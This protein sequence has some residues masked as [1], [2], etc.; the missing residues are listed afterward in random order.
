MID[1]TESLSFSIQANPGVYAILLGSG[2]SRAAEIPTG[3]EITLDL[4]RKLAGVC[5]EECEPD[6]ERWFQAKF[7]HA[8]DY[9]QL[10][11]ELAKTPAERQQLLRPYFERSEQE[12]EEGLKQ[13]TAA[14]HAISQLSA[15]GFIRVIVTTNFDRL[16]ETAMAE[17]GVVPTVLS[18]PDQVEGAL[19][20]IHTRCCVFK[21]HGD[22]LD[23]RIRNTSRELENYP[24]VF[25]QLLNRI[26]DEFGLVV[27]GWSATWDVALRD[28]MYR[29]PSRRFT[30]YWA[31]LGKPSDE[32]QRL[33]E[34]RRAEVVPI[35]DADSFFQ[36]VQHNVEAIEEFRKPHPLSTEAA[37]ASLK[38]YL[39]EH[40]YRLQLEGLIED[41]VRS[42]LTDTSGPDFDVN[43]PQPTTET[44]TGRVRKFESVC[45]TLVAMATVGG[46]WG[47]AEHCETWQRALQRLSMVPRPGGKVEWSDLR[48]YPGMLLLYT[49]G[50][51]AVEADRL[52]FLGRVFSTP[53]HQESNKRMTVVQAFAP[54]QRFE[55]RGPM[56]ML[57]GMENYQLPLNEWMFK[58]LRQF[59]N[60][61]IPD[62]DRYRF[63]FVKLEILMSLNSVYRPSPAWPG[64]TRGIFLYYFET[65]RAV[66]QEITDSI[67][68]HRDESP[69][70]RADIFG[71]TSEDCMQRID[72]L[73]QW[74]SDEVIRQFS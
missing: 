38:R 68:D 32:A 51:G 61:L 19:P 26:F 7:N 22:Y 4:V 72:D 31:A 34:N 47:E 30:T 48:L 13:P 59:T 52:A 50:L 15:R 35:E 41:A 44:V 55:P 6:P 42:I 69:F 36:E 46:R 5:G 64:T 66:L 54:Y 2:V 53:V 57:E 27:C 16:L 62:E 56:T 49:L 18:S 20:L 9:S 28:A 11:D 29:A 43:E 17:A 63:N 24:E 1:P 73:Q 21:V 37:V 10:L 14:H 71:Q 40:K 74:I 65:S 33:I 67:A 70:V 60:G 3:W 25:N 58:T 8:P 12:R 39:S 45:S 23:T